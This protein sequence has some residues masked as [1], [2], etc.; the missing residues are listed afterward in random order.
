MRSS[1][2]LVPR[3]VTNTHRFLVIVVWYQKLVHAETG[4]C[5]TD[6]RLELNIIKLLTF[7]YLTS[8]RSLLN[9]AYMFPPCFKRFDKIVLCTTGCITDKHVYFV[10]YLVLLKLC[11]KRHTIED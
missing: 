9:S 8:T 4:Q 2:Y 3:N 10:V 6:L 5:V 11:G 1:R 7:V